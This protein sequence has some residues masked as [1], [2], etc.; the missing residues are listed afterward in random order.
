MLA[1]E[2]Q[3]AIV[4]K[5]NDKGSVLVK[6]LSEEFKVTEDSIRKDLTLLER[7]GLLKKAYGGA[8]KLRVNIHEFNASERV[9]KNLAEKQVI[10][11]KAYSM[12]KDHD[13]IFLDISTTNLELAKLLIQ[14][15]REVTVV[16]NMIEMIIMFMTPSKVKFIFI[17]GILSP[18]KDGFV[19]A[20]ANQELEKYHFDE[21]FIGVVGIDVEANKVSTYYVEDGTTKTLVIASSDRTYM[22]AE[23]RKLDTTGNYKFA[24]ISDFTGCIFDA[25]PD[26]KIKQ[27]LDSYSVQTI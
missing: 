6:E 21:A 18:G 2:R 7:K 8:V 12:I 5:V 4:T 24:Q 25:Q 22:L 3:N 16:T 9:G 23:T 26:N 10:A 17:G 11:K 19:G 27:I 14:E 20:L 15:N 1:E 13:M